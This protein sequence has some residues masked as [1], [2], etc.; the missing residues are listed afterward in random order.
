M[1][2]AV[3]SVP[4]V[5]LAQSASA[6]SISC[7]PVGTVFQAVARGRLLSGFLGGVNLDN[8]AGVSGV[9]ATAPASGPNPPDPVVVTGGVN[10]TVLNGIAVNA[11]GLTGTLSSLLTLAAPAGVGTLN[12]Y[13]EASTTGTVRGAS[14]A[15]TNAGQLALTPTSGSYPDFGTVNLQAILAAVGGPGLSD[16][17]TNVAGLTLQIGAVTGRAALQSACVPGSDNLQRDYQITR[18]NLVLTSTALTALVT[19]VT[20]ALTTIGNIGLVTV[21]TAAILAGN[22]PGGGQPI[23]ASLGTTPATLTIDLASLLGPAPGQPGN[24]QFGSYSAFLNNLPPNSTLL[25][26]SGLGVPAAALTAF[27][28]SLVTVLTQR[29]RENIRILGIP[30]N[31]A[32]VLASVLTLVLNVLNPLLAALPALVGAVVTTAITPVF[33]AL[34]DVIQIDVNAQNRSTN[35]TGPA[36]L[37]ALP[38]G[39]YDVAALYIRAVGLVNLLDLFIARGSVGPNVRTG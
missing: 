36:A 33:A 12:Q 10:A 34:R 5:M 21:D 32:G 26:D 28:T 15:I 7:F 20:T 6:V 1:A 25:V 24:T 22:L 11:T 8:V 27:T 35:P 13:A 4:A 19:Q 23:Q 39:R 16:L 37:E 2:G 18:L 14:G 3:W 17:L 31:G 29:L 38:V 9:T 30:L